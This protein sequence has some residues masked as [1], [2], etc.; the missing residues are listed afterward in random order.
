M[1]IKDLH[2]QG[3]S[4]RDIARITGHS[5]NSV[6]AALRERVPKPFAQPARGSNLDPF[7]Q[8]LKDRYKQH[9]LSAVRFLAELEPMGYC[10]SI[11]PLQRFI[12]SLRSAQAC[13][14]K[15]T[16]RFETPPGVQAQ[17][18]WACCGKL[19]DKSV[20]AFVIVLGFSRM[21]YVEFTFSMDLSTLLEC[22]KRAFAY[23]GGWPESILYDNMKQVRL[24][25]DQLNP[26][27]LDFAGHYGFSIKTHR[28]RRPRTKGKVERMVMLLV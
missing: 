16:V 15:A 17:A 20:Y 28:V 25:P 7:K 2:H 27:M 5:R 12:K 21:L 22:H 8:Y 1:D 3:H 24:G 4:I 19:D 23:F 13:A 26:L 6:R 14:D 9:H 10:G 11:Y 18:D